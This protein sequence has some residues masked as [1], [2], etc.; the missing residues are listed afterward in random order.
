MIDRRLH[1][2]L[3]TDHNQQRETEM[4][5]FNKERNS[6]S[7]CNEC[8]M[9]IA[10]SAAIAMLQISDIENASQSARQR[11]S[12]KLLTD[13]GNKAEDNYIYYHICKLQGMALML[14]SILCLS[15]CLFITK[16]I[17]AHSINISSFDVFI[18]SA[19]I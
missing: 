5:V 13:Q 15:M 3:L 10:G 18:G 14:F 9:A 1:Q 16:K 11:G 17:Y 19:I 2:P 7:R 12:Y 8:N 6:H 4:N